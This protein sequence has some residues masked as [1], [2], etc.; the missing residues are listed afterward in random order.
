VDDG[1]LAAEFGIFDCEECGTG[2]GSAEEVE[3]ECDC[4]WL[5][6]GGE[7]GFE[8]CLCDLEEAGC[9]KASM[10]DWKRR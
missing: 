6:L 2:L 9:D 1:G 3:V 5:V 10:W 8:M 4:V 7:R